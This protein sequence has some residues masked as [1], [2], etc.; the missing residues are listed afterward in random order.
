MIVFIF[1][2]FY[3][4]EL[5]VHIKTN[6][7]G[8]LIIFLYVRNYFFMIQLQVCALEEENMKFFKR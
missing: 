4:M 1:L 7:M 8:L 2:L 5:H 3:I 6:T